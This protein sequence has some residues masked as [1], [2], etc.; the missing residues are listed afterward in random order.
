M[1]IPAAAAPQAAPTLPSTGGA[2]T[3]HW[4]RI[5]SASTQPV[6]DPSAEPCLPVTRA[7][8]RSF[9]YLSAVRMCSHSPPVNSEE[10]VTSPLKIITA[11][12]SPSCEEKL[13]VA[14][15]HTHAYIQFVSLFCTEGDSQCWMTAWR[16]RCQMPQIIKQSPL[17]SQP[18]THRVGAVTHSTAGKQSSAANTAPAGGVPH[19]PKFCIVLGC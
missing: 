13:R 12:V 9:R 3:G 5:G 11:H 18:Q 1:P 17:P 6:P 2:S 7:A 14:P 4:A 10:V 15:L 8:P 16:S 19:R